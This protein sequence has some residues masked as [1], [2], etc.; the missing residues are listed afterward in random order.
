MTIEK[1]K[2]TDVVSSGL[3]CNTKAGEAAQATGVLEVVC[4]V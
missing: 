3:T 4:R 1:T 2:A